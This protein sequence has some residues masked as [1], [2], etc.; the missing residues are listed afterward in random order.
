MGHFTDDHIQNRSNVS[1][2]LVRCRHR[3]TDLQFT[4]VAKISDEP[5][6]L[7]RGC[8]DLLFVASVN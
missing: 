4:S 1:V 2:A 8:A 3:W 7:L 5:D 6:R